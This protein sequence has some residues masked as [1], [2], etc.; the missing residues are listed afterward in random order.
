MGFAFPINMARN[1]MD[2]I[3]EHGKLIRGYLGVTIQ[4]VSPEMAKAFGLSHG[5]GALIG[6]V[7]P[8]SAAAKA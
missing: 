3:V 4:A 6:D 1:V 2:Q 7:S 8:N 5:G